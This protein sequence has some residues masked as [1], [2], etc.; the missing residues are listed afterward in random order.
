MSWTDIRMKY[1]HECTLVVT[2]DPS[3]RDKYRKIKVKNPKIQE[4]I[5]Q[6]DGALDILTVRDR[7]CDLNLFIHCDVSS[8]TKHQTP[9]DHTI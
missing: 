5:F 7:S 2:C 1:L 4:K 6:V 9:H 8:D 3:E